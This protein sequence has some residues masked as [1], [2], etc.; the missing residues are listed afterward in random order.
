MSEDPS[1]PN[2]KPNKSFAARETVA[3][4]AR[5]ETMAMGL[6]GAG[7]LLLLIG[8]T[9][10]LLSSRGWFCLVLGGVL[11]VSGCVENVRSEVLRVR[12]KLE[13]D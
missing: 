8:T 1:K 10:A 6:M 7:A 9:L 2:D 4:A 5:A 11:F 3:R 13:K 12:A